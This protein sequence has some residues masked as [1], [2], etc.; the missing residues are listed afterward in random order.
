MVPH[1]LLLANDVVFLFIG[2]DAMV[3]REKK[4]VHN[5]LIDLR[6]KIFEAEK[7]GTDTETLKK[8]YDELKHYLLKIR[9]AEKKAEEERAQKMKGR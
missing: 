5:K 2:A 3:N 4:E 8:E 6:I 1:Y 9:Q 7:L